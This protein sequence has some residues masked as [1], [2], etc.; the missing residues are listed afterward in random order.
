MMTS[1][2]QNEQ[3]LEDFERSLIRDIGKVDGF[4]S[5]L[6]QSTKMRLNN[7]EPGWTKIFFRGAASG[8]LIASTDLCIDGKYLDEINIAKEWFEQNYPAAK[9]KYIITHE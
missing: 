3:A 2:K 5:V 8:N 6:F 9:D 4:H 1:R 7:L